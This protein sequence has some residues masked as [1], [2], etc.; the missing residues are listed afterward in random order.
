ML[1]AVLKCGQAGNPFLFFIFFALL[2]SPLLFPPSLSPPPC[3]WEPEVCK[4]APNRGEQDGFHPLPTTWQWSWTLSKN[5][6]VLK[7]LC[8]ME[9]IISWRFICIITSLINIFLVYRRKNIFLTG[10]R[11]KVVRKAVS[12]SRRSLEGFVAFLVNNR[13]SSVDGHLGYVAVNDHTWTPDTTFLDPG[14]LV[15]RL[16]RKFCFFLGKSVCPTIICIWGYM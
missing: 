12:Q 2:F 4:L 5:L 14:F 13:W 15:Q 8:R 6:I 16:P 3:Q 1:K 9:N 10:T 11:S 7:G